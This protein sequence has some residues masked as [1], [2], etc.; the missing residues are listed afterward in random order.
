MFGDLDWPLNALRRFVSISWASCFI[1]SVHF[2]LHPT[3]FSIRELGTTHA[4]Y[5]VWAIVG[6]WRQQ[7]A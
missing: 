2:V 6:Y 5:T 7:E 1:C 3:S 4:R